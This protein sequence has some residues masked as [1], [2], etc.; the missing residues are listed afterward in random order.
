[1]QLNYYTVLGLKRTATPPEIKAA[2]KQLAIQYHPDKHRGDLHFEERFK[3]VN[4]AYQVLSNPQK[5]RLYDL[6]LDYVVQQQ[7]AHQYAQQTYAQT[8]Q[9]PPASVRERHYR[10]IA[11]RKKFSKKDWQ[12][13]IAFFL[14][15][16][17]GSL[18]VKV[19]MDYITAQNRYRNANAFIEQK[20]WSSAHSLLTEAIRFE[21]N[22]SEAYQ[23]RGIINQNFYKNYAAAIEDY[24]EVIKLGDLPLAETYYYRGQCHAQLRNYRQAEADFT[25]AIDY[26]RN[27][28]PPYFDRGEVRLLELNAWHEA[29]ADLTAYLQKPREIKEKNKALLYRG[30]AFYLIDRYDSAVRDYTTALRTDARNGRL[31]YLLGK[32]EYSMDQEKQACLHFARAYKLGYEPAVLDWESLCGHR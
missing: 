25:T 22:F 10:P 27:F 6:K 29:I 32:A 20:Q 18:V 21:D 2:Y 4:E 12:I 7:R 8:R 17:V 14:C 3:Q 28:K 30:F 13:T 16:L 24:N 26:D 15:L 19:V 31:Y 23:K 9:R 5:R 1:M 11:K